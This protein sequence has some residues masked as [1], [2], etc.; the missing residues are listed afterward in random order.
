M[1]YP[2]R[3]QAHNGWQILGNA[4]QQ[5]G[6]AVGDFANEQNRLRALMEDAA[7]K[8]AAAEML[9]I[10]AEREAKTAAE[11][12]TQQAE[13]KRIRAEL[14]TGKTVPGKSV[15]GVVGPD[16]VMPY[17]PEEANRMLLKSG[18]LSGKEYSDTM[19]PPTGLSLEDRLALIQAQSAAATGKPLTE[20]QKSML[21][22]LSGKA[23]DSA[24][25]REIAQSN[26][27]FDQEQKLQDKFLGQ[28]KDFR[29][30]RDAYGRIQVSAKDPSP[31]GDLSLI[32]NYMKMLDPSSTVREGEFA[33]AAASGSYGDRIQAA[34]SKLVNGERLSPDQ[35]ADFLARSK[36][37]YAQQAQQA[38][39]TEG[40]TKKQARSYGLNE[41]RAVTDLGL[42]DGKRPT[43]AEY[44]T[45]PSGAEYTD[46][47]GN[48]RRK[49]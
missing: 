36:S 39:K 45:L 32:F 1:N 4:L 20:Y 11:Q 2:Q 26:K 7:Q 47:K 48:V 16:E 43:Y 37:L 31:A 15:G 21:G 9:R 8:K 6:Q 27:Q 30:V 46:P 18:D 19:K 44:A 49:K 28:T 25:N 33:T 41:S 38:K 34:A 5:G 22:I 24:A 10:K 3:P 13:S 35:R 40:E 17:D 14:A 42:A 12:E 29:E 23:A